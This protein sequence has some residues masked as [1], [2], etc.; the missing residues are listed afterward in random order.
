MAE[1]QTSRKW[2]SK[3]LAPEM[4]QCPVSVCLGRMLVFLINGSLIMNKIKYIIDNNFSP[5]N[6][7]FGF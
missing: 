3:V 6:Y 2:N 1:L 4:L 5:M 7:L